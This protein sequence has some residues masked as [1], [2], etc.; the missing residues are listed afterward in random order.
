MSSTEKQMKARVR[1]NSDEQL[2]A[3]G[4]QKRPKN[5]ENVPDSSTKYLAEDASEPRAMYSGESRGKTGADQSSMLLKRNNIDSEENASQGGRREPKISKN[6]TSPM[7]LAQNEHEV[8]EELKHGTTSKEYYDA[9]GLKNFLHGISYQSK[10]LI[11]VLKRGLY[12]RESINSRYCFA[13]GTEMNAAEKFDDIVFR[14]KNNFRDQKFIYRFVQAKHKID[15][16][17][18][19]G[20]DNL[21]SQE[22]KEE[23]RLSKYFV[24]FLRIRKNSFFRGAELRDFTICTNISL[25]KSLEDSCFE[26][27]NR[28]DEIFD[29]KT[30]KRLKL[31][32]NKFPKSDELKSALENESDCKELA[33]RLA[34][35]IMKGNV[36]NLKDGLF[37]LYH[38]ALRMHVI[39]VTD[40]KQVIKK[41]DDGEKYV[42]A[43]L[44][45]NFV[46]EKNLSPPVQNFRNAFFHEY[47]GRKDVEIKIGPSYVKFYEFKNNPN[48]ENDAKALASEIATCITHAKNGIVKLDRRK[49]IQKYIDELAGF[50]FIK[51]APTEKDTYHFSQIFFDEDYI[52]PGDLKFFKEELRKLK[53]KN[54]LLN[55]KFRIANFVTCE[56]DELLSQPDLPDEVSEQNMTDFFNML[57]F[58]VG[59]PDEKQLGHIIAKDM[60]DQ[61]NLADSE[62]PTSSLEMFIQNWMKDKKGYFLTDEDGEIFFEKVTQ[63]VSALNVYGITLKYCAKIEDFGM[64]FSHIPPRLKSFLTSTN[65]QIFIL[66][67]SFTT[68][69]AIKV[70]QALKDTKA[71]ETE[72]SFI[73][74]HLSSIL[75]AGIKDRI[76]QAFNSEVSNNL[77]VIE[78]GAAEL[79]DRQQLLLEPLFSI[80]TRCNKKKIILITCENDTLAEKLQMD[81]PEIK[82]DGV[83]DDKNS[84]I[85]LKHHSQEALWNRKIEFQGRE[86]ALSLGTLLTNK[87]SKYIL[88]K[89]LVGEL[90]FKLI[91][92]KEM[93]IGKAPKDQKYDN[94]KYYFIQR[95]FF[96]YI[97]IDVKFKENKSE[98]ALIDKTQEIAESCVQATQDI[99]LIADTNE[100][101][102]KCCNSCNNNIHWLKKS[103]D[104]CIWQQSRG[105]VSKLREFMK[106]SE[107]SRTEYKLDN[108]VDIPDKVVLIAAE[109]GMGKSV[110]LS[111]L[112]V[113]T[114]TVPFPVWI[115]RCNLMEYSFKFGEWVK[116][117][118]KVNVK[119][120]VKFLYKI[121]QFKL[122][123]ECEDVEEEQILDNFLD[124]QNN[125]KVYF[126]SNQLKQNKN[127]SSLALFEIELF[128][129]LYNQGRI[130][131]LLD[132][133]DE[134]IPNYKYQVIKVIENLI[135][136]LAKIWM[137]T[138]PIGIRGEAE[139]KFSVFS[140]QLTSFTQDDQKKFLME[141]WR[142]KL[143]P[144]K[145]NEQCSSVYIDNLI[146]K[147][148][149]C[150]SDLQKKFLS[151]PLQAYM[152]AEVSTV[153]FKQFHESGNS[154][155]SEKHQETLDQM[156]DLNSL[157]QKFILEK[158]RIQRRKMDPKYDHNRY[159]VGNSEIDDML[160][161]EFLEWHRKLAIYVTFK[162][163]INKFPS[164]MIDIIKNIKEGKVKTGIVQCIP[165]E[166]PTF[167]HQTFAEYFTA[168]FIWKQFKLMEFNN[169]EKFID[170]IIFG[171]LIKVDRKEI[172]K[173]LKSIAEK[174]LKGNEMFPQ[175][176][177]KFETLMMKLFN[178]IRKENFFSHYKLVGPRYWSMSACPSYNYSFSV[179]L[180]IIEVALSSGRVGVLEIIRNWCD[181]DQYNLL[182]V[183][184]RLGYTEFAKALILMRKNS[185]H[186]LQYNLM[187]SGWNSSILMIAIYSGLQNITE[188]FLG[189]YNVFWKDCHDH[190]FISCILS[191]NNV[192][193]LDF[194]FKN[195]MFD[196]GKPY[197]DNHQQKLL[198][199]EA[200]RMSSSD[201]VGFLMD[202][203]DIHI[204]D[205]FISSHG[206][207]E[208]SFSLS[209][210]VFT[211][212]EKKMELGMKKGIDFANTSSMNIFLSHVL[213]NFHRRE[214]LH[215]LMRV[216]EISELIL[217]SG[218]GYNCKNIKLSDQRLGFGFDF[219]TF[220]FERECNTITLHYS[221]CLYLICMLLFKAEAMIHNKFD[222]K[223]LSYFHTATPT[224]FRTPIA[225]LHES[226][227]FPP[228]FFRNNSFL[229][230]NRVNTT[231]LDRAPASG[232]VGTLRLR[233]H[234]CS[235]QNR[236]NCIRCYGIKYKGE[237]QCVS[238]D[239]HDTATVQSA[240]NE[241]YSFMNR[242]PAVIDHLLQS[243]STEIDRLLRTIHLHDSP[244][245]INRIMDEYLLARIEILVPRLSRLETFLLIRVITISKDCNY[246]VYAAYKNISKR[247][248]VSSKLKNMPQEIRKISSNEKFLFKTRDLLQILETESS[249]NDFRN[250]VLSLVSTIK[251][252]GNYDSI[253]EVLTNITQNLQIK[254][255]EEIYEKSKY[256]H[257]L[258]KK[259]DKLYKNLTTAIASDE[260]K[261]IDVILERAP[262]YKKSIIHGQDDEF[263]SPLHYVAS[264]GNAEITQILLSHGA[265][266][267]LRL[268]EHGGPQLLSTFE[269]SK[270]MEDNETWA[271]DYYSWTPLHLAALNGHNE[272]V[273]L[274][275][276]NGAKVDLITDVKATNKG[277]TSLHL[278]TLR[279]HF[280]TVL[281]LLKNGA[282]YDAKNAQ[283]KTPLELAEAGSDVAHVLQCT[284]NSFRAVK[285]HKKDLV[286]SLLTAYDSDLLEAILRAKNSDKKTLLCIARANEQDDMVDLLEEMFR[287]NVPI[288]FT[289]RWDDSN[290]GNE[291]DLESHSKFDSES[292]SESHSESYSKQEVLI[293]DS[294]LLSG[295]DYFNYLDCMTDNE[296][297]ISRECKTTGLPKQGLPNNLSYPG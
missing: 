254:D 132:G 216:F 110:I 182:Y 169:F 231:F 87:E 45:E 39:E 37:K 246:S 44:Y 10:L 212:D 141:F 115:V 53:N 202:K 204:V 139:N 81:F 74:I 32:L 157:Y 252:C 1:K 70:I 98:F 217:K 3:S 136:R 101:F 67:S 114:P 170:D 124:I 140:Y 12:H 173:F 266:P 234:Y 80:T 175:S 261:E 83:I 153:A 13:I 193:V 181:R 112:A 48:L 229:E 215:D 163:E 88:G 269:N 51:K 103:G 16:T 28:D 144:V 282:C 288:N 240:L 283:N 274:L 128:T 284:H 211:Y 94:A 186:F 189:F 104:D 218:A 293:S 85:D 147:F 14:Y 58:A 190:T 292:Y 286:S 236:M 75:H 219:K 280:D 43:K 160:Y 239:E 176:E 42:V 72:G 262:N 59:M 52:L 263:G 253:G 76:I 199:L 237:Q 50:V 102:I 233:G 180:W 228:G 272:V 118:K 155:L 278:A 31:N 271:S 142:E 214:I 264:K 125:G 154:E 156:L 26:S 105:S 135:S 207:S 295:L 38:R 255:L 152:I 68:L 23:F 96:R 265:N 161:E 221:E 116:S 78:C 130:V 69:S 62:F 61:L 178:V 188:F 203:T 2:S 209:A 29:F 225:S 24:S 119:E 109:A 192:K 159:N 220:S 149:S 248:Q 257:E 259:L 177:E 294:D 245:A 18:V 171:N 244:M 230:R 27:V 289:Q 60:S 174:D 66:I 4:Y 256:F 281:L 227:F 107:Q 22:E 9:A 120:A 34:E 267:N 92:S 41:K 113:N 111:H 196:I 65:E 126:K 210:S 158:Y 205:E 151:V 84:L 258:L 179:V 143:K 57:I 184:T 127:V 121:T 56:E 137:T 206:W 91:E 238:L 5:D 191:E 33:K 97:N 63:K 20:E 222:I 122:F 273:L 108:I 99:I 131:L 277:N 249:P 40:E 213:Q 36:I 226:P 247:I 195:N 291:L 198:F 172:C 89:A 145:L 270:Q 232:L 71:Y 55:L 197:I 47:R 117:S 93:K 235:W 200:M 134:I 223:S 243:Y 77:L 64:E 146:R 138:R 268:I 185:K 133:F 19:L 162:G 168:D 129:V 82:W 208:I 167:I 46:D 148:S 86:P 201:V 79:G 183:C 30:G 224:G 123:E 287:S 15:N 95:S 21:L 297:L 290:H 35:C 251:E 25:N 164:K 166:M 49:Y 7:K 296:K 194:L 6:C 11:H 241:V 279:N 100:D 8:T 150:T 106:T 276:D 260:N 242:A 73:A 285:E 275:L 17:K 54:E 187:N 250:E 90:L 165:N